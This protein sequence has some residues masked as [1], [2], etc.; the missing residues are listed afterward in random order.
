MSQ[1]EP[2]R[3]RRNLASWVPLDPPGS[4]PFW[5]PLRQPRPMHHTRPLDSLKRESR[6]GSSWVP[7]KGTQEDPGGK[8]GPGRAILDYSGLPGLALGSLKGNPG[9]GFPLRDWCGV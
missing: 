4:W 3:T 7:F 8:G 6:P 5:V 2:G 1:Q 9:L